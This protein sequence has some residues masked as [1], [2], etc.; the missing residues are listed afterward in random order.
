MNENGYTETS[1]TVAIGE[2][3]ISTGAADEEQSAIFAGSS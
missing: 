2:R 3:Q 1:W